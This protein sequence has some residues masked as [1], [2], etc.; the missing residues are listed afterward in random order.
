MASTALI[1]G[2]GI[3]GLASGI[4]LRR[5][6][7]RI[8]IFERAS[9]HSAPGFALNL[10]PNAVA[11][12]R[13]LGVGDDVIA[14]GS[15]IAATEVR[16]G[17]GRV[18]KRFNVRSALAGTPSVAV[19]RPALHR[20]LLDSVGQDSVH[21][22]SEA[23]AFELTHSGVVLTLK[24]GRSETGDMLLG[25]DG[26]ASVIRKLLHPD[27]APA[28]P[29]GYYGLRGL[30]HG[31]VRLLGDLSVVAY[32]ARGIEAATVRAG[33]DAV[34]W[35]MSL[36]AED[37]AGRRQ[38]PAAVA[39]RHAA[40]LDDGFRTIVE[41]TKPEDM[42]LDELYDRD[43]IEGWGSGLVTL[44]GD[45]AHPML[46]HTGQGAAQALE[47][48]VALSLALASA[49]NPASSLRRYERVRSRRTRKIVMRG[50]RI[51]H[52]TT[53]KSRL[54]NSM[55]AAAIRALPPRAMAAAYLLAGRADP[56][57]ALR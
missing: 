35:Y 57:R 18:L 49:A 36:L 17:G 20:I 5:A 34:Y 15:I 38:D 11:A 37:V 39:R 30:A 6:G 25:A 29:S 41:A 4:A 1:V 53:T 42:R 13:E 48:A 45:A 55:R 19:L 43:P 27:E 28:R 2:A 7:W 47:D 21:L 32:L 24:D 23:V 31:V 9:S 26:V 51:A 52:V 14:Q 12:L 22:S 46:P 54:L 44:L 40:M 8:R 33:A 3:G 56:H 16:G 10:A 50:R